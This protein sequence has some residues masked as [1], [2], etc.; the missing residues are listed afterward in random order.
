MPQIALVLP[1]LLSGHLFI[2][3]AALDL[4]MRAAV[5]EVGL[6]LLHGAEALFA[7]QALPVFLAVVLEV[8]SELV[9]IHFDFPSF[10]YILQAFI[11]ILY[12]LIPSVLLWQT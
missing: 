1:E 2:T 8:M 12:R 10:S 9:N 6:E 7:I 5:L 11:Q 4:N 3:I